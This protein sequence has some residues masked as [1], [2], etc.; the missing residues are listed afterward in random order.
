M[1][2]LRANTALPAVGVALKYRRLWMAGQVFRTARSLLDTRP[3]LHRTDAAIRG[4]VFRPF[5]A[6]VLRDGPFRRMERAGVAAGWA[7]IPRDLNALTE[8]VIAHDG[9]RFA[10]R[11]AA[12]G[13]AGGI[14]RCVGVRLPKAVRRIE[15]ENAGPSA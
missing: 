10:V 8:T 14:A 7:D 9:K 4:H 5:P 6:L 1:W 11:G 15:E 3:V 2:V 13:V 12:V